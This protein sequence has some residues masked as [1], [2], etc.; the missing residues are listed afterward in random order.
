MPSL[1]AAQDDLAQ[2]VDEWFQNLARI[3]GAQHTTPQVQTVYIL[4]VIHGLVRFLGEREETRPKITNV[5]WGTRRQPPNSH[6]YSCQYSKRR[7]SSHH[8]A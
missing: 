3:Q 7:T 1:D 5:H 2:W 6:L 8:C 4:P